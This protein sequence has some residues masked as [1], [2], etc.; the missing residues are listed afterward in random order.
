[1]SDIMK[2]VFNDKRYQFGYNDAMDVAF[3]NERKLKAK[4]EE[5]KGIL[6]MYKAS[7][8]RR[9]KELTAKVEGLTGGIRDHIAWA[10]TAVDCDD[11]KILIGDMEEQEGE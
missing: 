3:N 7:A 2:K 4:V 9:I 10:D 1:M 5:E 6:E 8:E 11:L